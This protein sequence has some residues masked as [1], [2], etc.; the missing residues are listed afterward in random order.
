MYLR[1]ILANSEVDGGG[2]AR[3]YRTVVSHGGIARWYRT[4]V[5]HGGIARWYRVIAIFVRPPKTLSRCY[6]NGTG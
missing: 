4:V 1:I 5:S 2:I 6:V 3:W